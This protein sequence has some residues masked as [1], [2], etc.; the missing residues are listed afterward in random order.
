MTPLKTKHSSPKIYDDTGG[1]VITS[2]SDPKDEITPIV[3][4]LNLQ[5]PNLASKEEKK[6]KGPSI[7]D[8]H[9]NKSG[10]TSLMNMKTKRRSNSF[11]KQ[12]P[13]QQ[14]PKHTHKKRIARRSSAGDIDHVRVTHIHAH[15]I[16]TKT[17]P[18]DDIRPS[19]IENTI[20]LDDIK[21][22]VKLAP[23]V[24][25]S[26]SKIYVKTVPSHTLRTTGEPRPSQIDTIHLTS[27][28]SELNISTASV[29]NYEKSIRKGVRV[30]HIKIKKKKANTTTAVTPLQS[31][32]EEEKKDTGDHE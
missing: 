2:I 29:D 32:I 5:S 20:R 30:K 1:K 3:V 7:V 25:T 31:L 11:G 28:S 17:L 23:L 12:L 4:N 16:A 8:L 15:P 19:I 6:K 9:L 10:Q 26:N 24:E 22:N 14:R 21:K 18:I 27:T 13:K